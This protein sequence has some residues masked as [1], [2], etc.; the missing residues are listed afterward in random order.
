MQETEHLAQFKIFFLFLFFLFNGI[1]FSQSYPDKQVDSLLKEGIKNIIVQNYSGAEKNF[2]LLKDNFSYLPFGDIYLAAVKIASA[3]DYNEE[4]ETDAINKLLGSAIEQSDNLLEEDENDLWYNY[5]VA[6]AEGYSAYFDALTGS[7]LSALSTGTNSINAFQKCLWIDSTFYESYIAI[8]TFEYWKS[9]KTEFMSWLPFMD[10]KRD[11]GIERLI[12]AIDS[13]SYN[14][15]LAV[16]SL[17]WI[18]IDK[19]D[20]QSAV[21]ISSAALQNFPESRSFKWGLARAYE[22]IDP[23]KSIELYSQIISS[24]PSGKNG[25]RINE[26]TLKHL[27][28][29]QHFKLGNYKKAEK[30][31]EDIL[32][33]DFNEY[34][35]EKLEN[36]LE[37][38]S[39]F[40]AELKELHH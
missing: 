35:K 31:C 25:N 5:F 3:Y 22:D 12:T 34:E 40:L 13:S 6:L 33:I 37:R 10:D 23:E 16:N 29:Q 21:K 18:Y 17:I 39:A 24:Y 36:R 26:I 27:I 14:S 11:K 8:G 32:K 9:R 4:F 28:A 20:Y 1:S 7:W 2:Q 30:I 15:Y 19:K 38:I